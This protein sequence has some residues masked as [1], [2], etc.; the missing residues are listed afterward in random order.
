M[1]FVQ[2]ENCC[3]NKLCIDIDVPQ[4]SV[5]GPILFLAYLSD[6]NMC[7]NFRSTLYA[8]DSVL[9]M[10]IHDIRKLEHSVN[11]EFLKISDWVKNN[12]LSSNSC[13]TSYILFNRKAHKKPLLLALMLNH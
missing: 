2:G 7:S 8:N 1:Q 13:I 9:T 4:G 10:A 3:F 11:E 12:R 6:I 5:L